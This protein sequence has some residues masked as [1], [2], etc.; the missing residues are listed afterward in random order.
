[1]TPKIILKFLIFSCIFVNVRAYCYS[2]PEHS[3]SKGDIDVSEC[4]FWT[5]N[6]FVVNFCICDVGYSGPFFFSDVDVQ[7]LN[8]N[9]TSTDGTS[10][11]NMNSL[12][13][14]SILNSTIKKISSDLENF[15]FVYSPGIYAFVVIGSIGS[16]LNLI[17]IFVLYVHIRNLKIVRTSSDDIRD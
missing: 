17:T 9:S 2:C 14:E 11:L 3:T 1:M 4:K 12:T 5:Y 15:I 8:L 7:C 10:K 6:F 16:I 13:T